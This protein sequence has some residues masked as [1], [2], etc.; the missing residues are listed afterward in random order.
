MK[1]ILSITLAVLLLLSAC[2]K[3]DTTPTTAATSAPTRETTAPAQ[4]TAAPTEATVAAEE[5]AETTVVTAAVTEPTQVTAKPTEATTAPTVA[6]E[7]PSAATKPITIVKPTAKP[8][9][10]TTAPTAPV[11]ATVPTQTAAPTEAESTAAPTE[12]VPT[13]APTE[14]T[15][16]PAL[17]PIEAD[18]RFDS[19]EQEAVV[20]T[21]LAFLD[22]GKYIQYDDTRFNSAVQIYRWQVGLYG[23]EDHTQQSIGYTNCAA[24]TYD[25]YKSALDYDI[26]AYTTANLTAKGTSVRKYTYLPTGKET[27]AEKAAVEAEFRANLQVGDI[28]VVRYN[29]KNEGNGHAMLYVG[30]EVLE[31]GMDIIH[32]TGS[33]YSYAEFTEKEERN[34]TVQTMSTKR[35]FSSGSSLYTFSKLKSLCLI[36]PLATYKGGVPENT[37]NRIRNLEGIVAEKLSSHTKGMTVNPGEI[38]SFTF[39]VSNKNDHPVTLE[40]RDT[41]PANT[42]YINGAEQVSGD[43]LSWQLSVPANA[44]TMVSY[45]VQVKADA[46]Y[47]EAVVSESTVGGVKTVCP[48]VYIQKTLTPRQQER[49]LSAAE[50]VTGATGLALADAIYMEALGQTT[51]LPTELTALH[52]SFF[53]PFPDPTYRLKG[54][55]GMLELIP[56]GMFGGRKIVHRG[57]ASDYMRLEYLRTRMVRADDLIA[58]DIILAVG[59]PNGGENLYMYTGEKMLNLSTGKTQPAQP[60]LNMLLA[61]DRFVVIRPS[62]GM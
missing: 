24:F 54:E 23:P 7:K 59:G 39:S 52:D 56:A 22:R 48:K 15:D 50:E 62:V 36:R 12:A 41:V 16:A 58:G 19:L 51:G 29:G 40:I 3:Q 49:I 25:V 13:T 53:E 30:T 44:S 21:A 8:T 57:I 26:G 42:T 35:L 37:Q 14:V 33:S 18:P 9:A 27:A 31:N 1:R 38:M 28:I 34:G 61:Y 4:A 17:P 20:K 46:P 32:S 47:G 10:A 2:G 6:T 55:G 5:T 45:T 11:P 43:S 60:L